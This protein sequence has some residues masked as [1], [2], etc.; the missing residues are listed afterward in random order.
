MQGSG[1]YIQP[2]GRGLYVSMVLPRP[3]TNLDNI[4]RE[5]WG[6][7]LLISIFLK[8]IVNFLRLGVVHTNYDGCLGLG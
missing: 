2:V 5:C 8:W 4:F 3:W 1:S 7:V 6:H